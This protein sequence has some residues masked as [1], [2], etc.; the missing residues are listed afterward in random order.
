MFR[1]G[2]Q[3]ANWQAASAGLTDSF[4]RFLA[5]DPQTPTTLY[6]ATSSGIFRTT[7]G[8]TNWAPANDGL[9]LTSLDVRSLAVDPAT[10]AIVYGAVLHNGVYRSNDGGASWSAF[11][12]NLPELGRDVLTLAIDPV[13]PSL[14]YAGTSGSSV[15][16]WTQT[17][18]VSAIQP[19]L[20]PRGAATSVTL[21]G[22]NFLSGA[23]T[24]A[25]M[26]GITVSNVQVVSPTQ[27]TATF[28]I[29]SG[30]AV[31][32]RN[33]S[34]T[35]PHASANTVTFT[36]VDPFP[37]L[38][39]STSHNGLAEGYSE[40]YNLTVSN[41]G[42]AATTSSVTVTDT[43]PQGL[44][45]VSSSGGGWACSAAGQIVTCVRVAPLGVNESSSVTLTVAVGNS[46]AAVDH[47]V[48]V[49]TTGDLDAGNNTVSRQ[50]VVSPTPAA[51]LDITPSPLVAGQ[52]ARAAVTLSTPFPHDV[53]G[54]LTLGF[55]SSAVIS[56]DDPAIQ[57][58][59]GGR[60]VSFV[61]AANTLEARFA[62]S[63][64][65]GPIGFQAGTVAGRLDVRRHARGRQRDDNALAVGG[66][67]VAHDSGAGAYRPRSRN[68]NRR[69]I[70]RPDS[71]VVDD[72]GGDRGDPG[73][74]HDETYSA[75]L[76][77]RV[78]VLGLGL[79]DDAE[80]GI[81]VQRLVYQQHVVRQS[82]HASPAAGHRRQHQGLGRGEAAQQPRHVQRHVVRSAVA[83]R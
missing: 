70:R 28:T 65:A 48:S 35:T 43:L 29:D 18:T 61:I 62:D 1:S 71:A 34:V 63:P 52:Q 40:S 50:L 57:F 78:G 9:A 4:V 77:R 55:T 31:G 75:E 46:P 66:G 37:D 39:L 41:V 7:N 12:T 67:R 42:T 83:A 30:A 13:T 56:G 10:P 25:P 58:A 73:V 26:A 3:G 79:D 14:V 17:P 16:R 23:T 22:T 11:N 74:H 36:V 68:A 5:V 32:A 72:A 80:R 19:G 81:A 38:L 15:V 64:D 69:R 8:A 6:A 54:T 59:T 2:D 49:D 53:F 44:S 47:Q 21:T 20:G 27:L 45:F 82:E 33:V 60:E 76:R 24:F 51:R